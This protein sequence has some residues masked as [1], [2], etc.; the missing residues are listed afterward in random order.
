MDA[1]EAL[2]AFAELER[3]AL[4]LYRRFAALYAG[5]PELAAMWREMSDTEAAHFAT[6]TLAADMVQMEPGGVAAPPSLAPGSL[7]AARAVLQSAERKATEGVL[8]AGEAV[9]L[10]LV[11][12]SSELPRIMD[13]LAWVPGR[14]KGSV[15]TGVAAGLEAHLQC[16]ERLA[17]ASG[18]ADVAEKAR[19]LHAVARD[20]PRAF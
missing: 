5:T 7:D 20:L 19:A 12:E 11:L 8:P 3:R 6:L 9:Q 18:R 2:T 16:L 1:V 14:A 17:T 4:E 13:L 15:T 10:A